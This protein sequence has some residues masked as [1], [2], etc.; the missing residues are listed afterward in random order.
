M[1]EVDIDLRKKLFPMFEGIQSTILLSCLQGHMGEA[2]VNDRTNP[3]AAQVTIGIFT[4]YGGDPHA[5]GARELLCNLPEDALVIVHTDEWKKQIETIHQGA[6]EKFHRYQFKKNAGDLDREHL[7][8]LLASLPEGYELKKMDENI[9]HHPSLQ[10]VSEDFTAQF[11]SIED[12][13]AR[14]EGFAILHEGQVM[15]GA[16]SYSIYDDGIEIEVGTH[17]D[18]RRK[19]LATIVSAALILDCLAKGKYPSWDAA[20]PESTELAKKLGYVYEEA[21]DT[22]YI[23]QR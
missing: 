20:N 19:G 3:T 13:L 7:Q 11:E 4:F 14:G 16:S 1:I 6:F 9:A 8:S 15:C 2:W 21:Y 18:H 5:K 22:Y 23:F 10:E 17:P 12:F